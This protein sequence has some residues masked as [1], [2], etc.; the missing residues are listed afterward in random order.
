M[1]ISTALEQLDKF[2]P[3]EYEHCNSENSSPSNVSQKAKW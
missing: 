1:C 3:Y 2:Y